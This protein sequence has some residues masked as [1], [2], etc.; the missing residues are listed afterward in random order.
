MDKEPD[1]IRS[2]IE[3]TRAQMTDT[4]EAIGYRAD[5]KARAKD[6]INEKKDAVV[7]AVTGAKDAIVGVA[8][9]TSDAIAST[10]SDA[11]PDAGQTRAATKRAVSVAQSNPLGL[12]IGG[13]ALGFLTGIALPSSRQ[14][15]E[16]LQPVADQI[17]D[18]ATDAGEQALEHGK[19]VVQETASSALQTAKESGKEHGQAMAEE[20]KQTAQE[21]VA[22]QNPSGS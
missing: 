13:A 9:D 6:S 5:V 10:L 16:R 3:D 17:K 8:T 4:I 19:Q 22:S 1:E 20:L 12:A 18:A 11:K 14:E 21:S 7:G 2:E 15:T